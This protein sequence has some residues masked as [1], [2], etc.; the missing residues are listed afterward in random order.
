M[1]DVNYL[2]V[3]VATLASFMLGAIWY[4]PMLFYKPWMEERRVGMETA[5]NAS[6]PVAL[7][8]ATAFVTALV[9]AYA[10]A[11]LLVT[12]AHHSLAI[13]VKRGFAAGVCWVAMSF[14][15]SYGFE[16]RTLRHWAINAGYFVAQFTIMGAI[17]GVMNG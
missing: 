10:M 6:P 16:Q 13:G 8:Y 14:G 5:R 1:P 7:L 11:V 15:S 2:A 3:L 17:L 9:A 12:P 4:S